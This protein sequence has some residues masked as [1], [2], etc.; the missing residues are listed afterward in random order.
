MA[1]FPLFK[2]RYQPKSYYP[3][4]PQIPWYVKH[5]PL[6]FIGIGIALMVIVAISIT[7]YISKNTPVAKLSYALTKDVDTGCDFHVQAAVNEENQMVFDGSAKI[8]GSQVSL[9]YDADYN[10]YTYQGV[11]LTQEGMSYEGNYYNDQWT[12]K[13]VNSK[14]L[15]FMDFYSDL[16]YGY[17]D[18]SSFL[19]FLGVTEKYSS[20]EFGSLLGKVFPRFATENNVTHMKLIEDGSTTTYAYNIDMDEFLTLLE[21]MSASSFFKSS[22]YDKFYEKIELNRETLRRA[23]VN[24]SFRISKKGYLENIYMSLESD[25]QHFVLNVDFDNFGEPTYTIPDSFYTAAEIK[26]PNQPE[27]SDVTEALTEAPT[28]APTQARTEA[29]STEAPTEGSADTEEENAEQEENEEE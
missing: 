24:M 6:L 28:Q 16:R 25:E 9:V 5:R 21:K 8:T 2:K 10:D 11:T 13:N 3:D 23:K 20:V 26:N 4:E 7:V 19:R 1:L 17:F 14:V 15:D 18:A 12:I 27:T 29:P 22:D